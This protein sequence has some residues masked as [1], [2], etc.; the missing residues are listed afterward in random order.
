[1][2]A[3]NGC[4]TG[5]N[6]V[7][8]PVPGQTGVDFDLCETMVRRANDVAVA[9]NHLCRGLAEAA[10]LPVRSES[11]EKKLCY[12]V[13]QCLPGRASARQVI[14]ELLR[15]RKPHGIV[16]IGDI[17]GRRKSSDEIREASALRSGSW[18][19]SWLPP[20]ICCAKHILCA[21]RDGVRRRA[22]P[23]GILRRALATEK[24]DV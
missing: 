1:M 4:G 5:A 15:V 22:C 7:L 3:E 16:L 20:S 9:P 12:R 23:R 18:K 21:S 8:V 11:F 19:Q 6:L 2:C 10:R 14:A 17:F 13:C 24:C